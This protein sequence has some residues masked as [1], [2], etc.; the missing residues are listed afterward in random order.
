GDLTGIAE[1]AIYTAADAA[2]AEGPLLDE[3]K[4]GMAQTDMLARILSAR[5]RAVAAAL[6]TA[7]GPERLRLL[8]ALALSTAPEA[9]EPLAAAP[10][11]AAVQ[12]V[13]PQDPSQGQDPRHLDVR[14]QLLGILGARARKAGDAALVEQV[15]SS[16]VA[17]KAWAHEHGFALKFALMRSAGRVG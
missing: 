1:L 6:Q 9:A 11:A 7:I 14:V 4:K 10:L 3:L 8:R 2:G 17:I 12:E 15:A 5:P 16:L 13:A